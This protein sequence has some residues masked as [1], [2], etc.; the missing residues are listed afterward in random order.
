MV[1]FFCG[2]GDEEKGT[3]AL[4]IAFFPVVFKATLLKSLPEVQNT[5]KDPGREGG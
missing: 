1:Y 4:L 2:G 5:R 3:V